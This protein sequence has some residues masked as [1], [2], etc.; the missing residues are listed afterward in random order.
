MAIPQYTN[1]AVAPNPTDLSR[2]DP[3]LSWVEPPTPYEDS[4]ITSRSVTLQWNSNKTGCQFKYKG[5]WQSE[6]SDWVTSNNYTSAALPNGTYSFSVSAKDAYGNDSGTITRSFIVYRELSIPE[7]VL[8]ANDAIITNTNDIKLVCTVPPGEAGQQYHFEFQIAYN[9][10]MTELV[11]S[12]T[13]W[14]TSVNGYDG[15]DYTAPVPENRGGNVGFTKTLTSRRKYWWRCRT[16]LYGTDRVS[17]PSEA[18]S[19]TVGI[20]ATKVTLSASPATL[21]ADGIAKTLIT[22]KAENAVGQLDAAMSGTFRFTKTGIANFAGSNPDGPISLPMVAGTASIEMSSSVVNQVNVVG[23]A[24]YLNTNNVSVSLNNGNV[25]VNFVSNRLPAAP[26][27]LPENTGTGVNLK[28]ISATVTGI[29]MTIPTDED[30]DKLHFKLEMDTVATFDSPDLM[31]METRFDRAGWEYYDGTQ[32]LLF[33][34]NGVPQGKTDGLV[35]YTTTS[36]LTDNKTYYC[37]A[38]AW[39]NYAR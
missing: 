6:W 20:L 32:W 19:F 36:S 34:E 26:E 38:A 15:F 30:N 25:T 28:I 17:T 23:E 22:A 39:D 12:G 2:T 8:P 9:A 27:W 37:R 33:P 3:V 21:R 7:P 18:R 13:Q 14:F 5:S 10:N 35:R 4:T 16:R 29:T 31:I 1:W 11:D 24:N